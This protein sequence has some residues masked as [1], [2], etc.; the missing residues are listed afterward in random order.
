MS[1]AAPP[2]RTQG[3]GVSHARPPNELRC[4]AER[5]S[6]WNTVG[7]DLQLGVDLGEIVRRLEDVE[8][9]VE[10]ASKKFFYQ[11]HSLR[12]RTFVIATL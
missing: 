8:M 11:P 9:P 2:A 4:L 12:Q 7:D 1:C 5:N 6:F 3:F 10:T